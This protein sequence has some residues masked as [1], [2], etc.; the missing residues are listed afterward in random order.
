MLLFVELVMRKG[1]SFG[2][3]DGGE[4]EKESVWVSTSASIES[5]R[6]LLIRSSSVLWEGETGGEGRTVLDAS[7][8]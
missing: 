1:E 3:G 2:C 5:R 4:L 8:G 6:D 7:V